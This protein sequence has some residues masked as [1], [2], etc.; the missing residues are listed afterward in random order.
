MLMRELEY[1]IHADQ[2]NWKY[3]WFGEHHALTEYS[4]M[5]APEVLMGYLAA[6][7]ERIH[8]CSG[9]ISFPHREG[10]PGALR[11]AGGDARP[12]HGGRYEL[13]TGRGAGSHEIATFNGLDRR[14]RPSRC[15]TRSSTRSRACGS[16]A[17]TRSRA[18]TSACPTPHNILPKPY[19]KG[20][21]PIWVA[22]GNP[23]TF[24][25]AGVDGHRRHRLQ[26]RA[27]RT[28]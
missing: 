27:G 6:P 2:H 16:S 24:A 22:C 4:H 5:S 14:R 10:A 17:T 9:I 13:G 15:G 11:R 20:H 19:G 26:L 18:S 7:T 8:L 25:K 23:A 12:H 28:A 1:A 3:A 21:P